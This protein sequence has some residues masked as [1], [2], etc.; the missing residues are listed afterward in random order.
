MEGAGHILAERIAENADLRAFVRR[1]TWEQGKISSRVALDKKEAV[2]K[3]EMYYDYQEVLKD[4]PS[5]RM[6][7]MRRGEKE[8][9]LFLSILA[10]IEEILAGLRERFI[11]RDKR[12]AAVS[13]ACRGGCL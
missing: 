1:L 8:E 5:H 2:T 12:L 6:L 11:Y 13:F 4:V 10:P 3:F 7:A 9:V